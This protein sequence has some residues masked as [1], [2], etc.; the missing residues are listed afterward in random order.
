MG[1]RAKGISVGPPAAG[2]AMAVHG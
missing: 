2:L 1:R